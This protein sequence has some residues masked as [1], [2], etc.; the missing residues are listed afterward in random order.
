M[1]VPDQYRPPDGSWM[2]E[3]MRGNPLALLTTNGAGE[4]GSVPQATHLPV[5]PGPGFPADPP[6]DLAGGSLLGHLNRANPHWTALPAVTQAL[7]VFSGP[8]AYVSPA[9]YR[10]SPAAPTWNFAVVHVHGTLEKIESPEETLDVVRATV[11]A[12]EAEFG[13]GWDMTDSVD[14]F[15]RLLPGV[16]AFRFTVRR[17]EGMFKL[18]QEQTPEVR[19]RVRRAFAGCGSSRHRETS[20]LMDRLDRP[21][22]KVPGTHSP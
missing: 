15:R 9:V 2:L 3:L 14:Y 16:G 8:H 17:A 7:L 12:F 5:I 21:D 11:R 13:H 22:A 6:A 19:D 1:Y 4:D 18:S 20:L 10:T